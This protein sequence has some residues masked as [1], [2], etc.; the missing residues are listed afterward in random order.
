MPDGGVLVAH[1]SNVLRLDSSGSVIQTYTAPGAN[2]LFALN[3]DPDGSSFWTGNISS[4][5]TIFHFRISD[6]A[7]LGQFNPSPFVDLA[8]L[9]VFGEITVG[10][11]PPPPGGPPGV[12]APASLLLLGIGLAVVGLV[13]HN[14]RHL[15]G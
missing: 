12:P 11:P 4:V 6:G 1:V 13:R 9:S 15:N 14:R 7:L 10:A 8:G 2:V 3:L 5:G